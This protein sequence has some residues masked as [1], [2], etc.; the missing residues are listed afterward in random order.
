[1]RIGAKLTLVRGLDISRFLDATL[2][3]AVRKSVQAGCELIQA[4]AKGYAPVKTGA[5]RD[6]ITVDVQQVALTSVKG[7]V[8]AHVPYAV[9][10]EY[11]TVHM[12]AQPFMRPAIDETKGAIED[13]FRENLKVQNLG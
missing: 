3:P 13:L 1:M 9:F 7:T 2:S 11:G 10:V 12:K 8:A 5:L 6:S 4:A